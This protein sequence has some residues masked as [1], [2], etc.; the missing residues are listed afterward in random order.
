[1]SMKKWT[2]AQRQVLAG[3]FIIYTAAYIGRLNLSQALPMITRALCLTNAEAG[4][5]QTAMAL[6]Y[7]VGQLIVGTAVDRFSPRR[8]ILVGMLGTAA[9]NVLFGL[10]DS[11]PA[12]LV[13]WALNGAAQSMLWTPII[14]TI[15]GSFDGAARAR[16]GFVMSAATIAGHLLSW[17]VA[18]WMARAFSWR[19]SFI[20]P[21]VLIL[22]VCP[23]AVLWIKPEKRQP[24]VAHENAPSGHAMRLD[25]LILRT[26]LWALLIGGMAT[27]FV[28]D[29]ITTWAPSMIENA[30]G[31]AQSAI[32]LSLMI[33]LL[34][35]LGLVMSRICFA[36][37]R[38]SARPSIVLM[39][40]L[41]TLAAGALWKFG[42]VSP[43]VLAGL[44]GL[45]CA[46]LYGN[47]PLITAMLPMEYVPAQRVAM[48]AGLMDCFIYLGAALSG[49]VVGYMSDAFGSE[50][51][52]AGWLG[53][54]ALGAVFVL[55]SIPGRKQLENISPG[56]DHK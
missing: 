4:A 45:S 15:A 41:G 7:A 18:G 22:L 23:L 5:M 38:G 44:L 8:F 49:V 25:R 34:N 32:Q 39:L 20:V 27:G 52:Y 47:T 46:V 36:R 42:R 2:M 16:A 10:L 14:K 19:L 35:I 56:G 55:A 17:M 24:F 28:R 9:C 48:V 33:P 54:C 13:I 31:D 12:L 1:M 26:G 40:T 6:T 3:C 11:Y 30:F 53:V 29:G 43:L 51:V 37:M 50:A 21:G